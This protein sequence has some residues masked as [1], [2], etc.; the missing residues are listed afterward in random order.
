MGVK[1]A[2]DDFGSLAG[3]QVLYCRAFWA[4]IGPVRQEEVKRPVDDAASYS[5]STRT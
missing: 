2:A 4:L 5:N 3:K 1:V